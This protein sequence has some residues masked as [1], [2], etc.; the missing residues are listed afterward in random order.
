MQQRL[1]LRKRVLVQVRQRPWVRLELAPPQ[2]LGLELP[3]LAQEQVLHPQQGQFL[4]EPR[5]LLV[6]LRLEGRQQLR[7]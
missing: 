4:L 3:L 5:Q 2:A 6:P 1:A 7:T